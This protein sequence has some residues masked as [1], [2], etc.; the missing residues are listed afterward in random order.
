MFIGWGVLILICLGWWYV[1]RL[2]SPIWMLLGC[3]HCVRGWTL[4]CTC[5]VMACTV[6]Y[7]CILIAFV[8]D[9][10]G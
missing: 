2:C 9:V 1:L 8:E 7:R 10:G 6:V 5:G 3:W 4:M